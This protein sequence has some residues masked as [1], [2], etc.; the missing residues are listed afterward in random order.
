MLAWVSWPGKGG[1]TAVAVA[2][3]GLVERL[4][5]GKG[6]G[7]EGRAGEETWTWRSSTGNMA[8]GGK[9]GWKERGGGCGGWLRVCF[10]IGAWP[11]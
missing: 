3:V 6:A 4:R 9:M 10:F 2:A 8:A 11:C 1:G 7:I 5:T